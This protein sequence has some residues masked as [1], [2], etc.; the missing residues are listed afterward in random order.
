MEIPENI[1]PLT[2]PAKVASEFSKFFDERSGRRPFSIFTSPNL[3]E[4]LQRPS[5]TV[6]L[7]KEHSGKMSGT[8]NSSGISQS[9]NSTRPGSPLSFKPLAGISPENDI[10][11]KL[12]M[13]EL[14]VP[15]KFKLERVKAEESEESS[16]DQKNL[17]EGPTLSDASVKKPKSW[18][19]PESWAVI[20]PLIP[21]EIPVRPPSQ[22]DSNTELSAIRIYK[23]DSKHH[24]TA[25]IVNMMDTFFQPS[26]LLACPLNTSALEICVTLTQKYFTS[27]DSSRYR[28]YVTHG[29]IERMLAK[30]EQPLLLQQNWLKEI[31][32]TDEDEMTKLGRDDHSYLFRFVFREVPVKN[33]VISETNF[34]E[35]NSKKTTKITQRTAHLA[36]ENLSVIPVSLYKNAPTLESLDLSKNTL[37]DLPEDFFEMLRSLRILVLKN[38]CLYS[39]PPALFQLQRLTHLNLSQNHLTSNSI[40]NL[41][42]LTNLTNLDLSCNQLESLPETFGQ[43]KNLVFL[44]LSTNRLSHFPI[45]IFEF[46]LLKDLNLSF[47]SISAIPDGIDFLQSLRTFSMTGNSLTYISPKVSN[48]KHLKLFDLRG[49]LFQDM[50]GI[51]SLPSLTELHAQY[52]NVSK[53]SEISW[54]YMSMLYLE[55]NGLT[56]LSFS[57]VLLNLKVLNISNCKLAGLPN[58]FFNFIP[59][60][61]TIILD[62]NQ[63]IA[64]PESINSTTWLEYLSV[65]SNS[66]SEIS[67]NFSRLINLKRLD[68]HGNNLKQIPSKIWLSPSLTFLNLSS[69]FLVGFPDP[70]TSFEALPLSICLT[71]LYLADN[72]FKTESLYN[73]SGLTNLII[74]NLSGNDIVDLDE[75]LNSMHKLTEFYI[76][77]NEITSLPDEID[78]WTNLK[79][80]H[81]NGNRFM[82]LSF[83]LCRNSQLEVLDVS[84][85][86]LKYNITN[87]PYDWN[88]AWNVELKSLNLSDNRRLEIKSDHKIIQNHT[89]GKSLVDFRNLVKLRYL[90][91]AQVN[92]SD[93]SVPLEST[94]LR[95]CRDWHVSDIPKIG[96]S[97]WC[98]RKFTFDTFDVINKRFLNQPGHHV[99][100]IFS[101]RSESLVSLHLY[102]TFLYDLEA[103]I[104]RIGGVDVINSP[105]FNFGTV[106]RRAFLNCNRRLSTQ[107][108]PVRCGSTATVFYI[109]NGVAW[110]ANVGDTMAVLSR[111]GQAVSLTTRHHAWSRPEIERIRSLGGYVSANGF[112]A[113]EL[114][115]CRAFG[116]FHLLPYV[117][118][119][120][121]ISQ[122]VLTER[123]EFIIMASYELWTFITYQ[124]AV[125]LVRQYPKDPT[126]GAYKLRDLAISY[127]ASKSITV[128]VFDLK[129]GTVMNNTVAVSAGS[130][131]SSYKPKPASKDHHVADQGLSRLVKEID[132]PTGEITLV[133]TDIKDSTTLWELYPAPMRVALR[134]HDTIM[135]RSLR[136]IGGYEVK[137]DGDSFMASFPNIQSALKWTCSVQKE[138]LEA[139]WPQEIVDSPISTTVYHPRDQNVPLLR[140]LSVRMG[141]H[142]G[143]PFSEIH[144]VTE[145]MDYTGPMVNFAARVGSAPTGGQIFVTPQVINQYAK[146][147]QSAKDDIGPLVIYDMGMMKFKGVEK[148]ERLF[149]VYPES[150]AARHEILQK[151]PSKPFIVDG[152]V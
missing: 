97:Q 137:N 145:R 49:N 26:V 79:I 51:I 46:K 41:T 141:M 58:D 9:L 100:A 115:I 128:I 70:P 39:V 8:E 57:Q 143:V 52:N 129:D 38:N 123:D 19:A 138:L 105:N 76:S 108:T 66:L 67:L 132:P 112:V 101:G 84:G 56:C 88:W 81:L 116:Y 40:R 110:V 83:D 44:N 3:M 103:E 152:Q 6:Y 107:P 140:G 120:P 111:E 35:N 106:L 4:S 74:L 121:S 16:D 60:V 150:L 151:E 78:K 45:V 139:D 75:N 34:D 50:S 42:I 109:L 24:R 131:G 36:D 122:T 72:R 126:I 17:S 27:Y 55:S 30:D 135:R 12:E 43:L 48:L 127:G 142:V 11:S 1:L 93:E 73:L 113:G 80:L 21:S 98:G 64:L 10:K 85:N 47:N 125:D 32:Y 69:N 13:L 114:D 130:H 5:S 94:S 104:N 118:A 71:E 91:V 23:I 7:A 144:S 29:G 31:G 86:N 92:I 28:L 134:M 33:R 14:N 102:D 148:P 87:Y 89:S 82:S 149:A 59:N 124:M 77:D 117:N 15:G 53:I 68:L 61:H 99:A 65:S 2:E 62:K 25:S 95:V 119:N 136:I 147:S 146:L 133:F 22:N 96:I 18:V 90:N 63:L 37:L 54:K 20:A